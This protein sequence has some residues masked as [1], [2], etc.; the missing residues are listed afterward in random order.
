MTPGKSVEHLVLVV[1]DVHHQLVVA[2]LQAGHARRFVRHRDELDGVEIGVLLAAVADRL[3]AGGLV[4]VEA[5]EAHGRVALP[6]DQPVGAGADVLGGVGHRLVAGGVEDRLGED[7]AGLGV[8]GQ[9]DEDRAVGLGEAELERVVVD[10]GQLGRLLHEALADAAD[11][12]PA[13]DGGDGVG[14]LQLLAVVEHDALAQGHGVGEAVV[15]DGVGGHQLGDRPVLRV[16]GE[17]P[18]VGA[19]AEDGDDLGGRLV[20][21]EVGR[22][23]DGGHAQRA[24]RRAGGGVVLHGAEDGGGRLSRAGAADEHGQG[25]GAEA[26]HGRPAQQRAAVEPPPLPRL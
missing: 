19:V 21:V 24:A 7:R 4:V 8:V 5:L 12:A 11:A 25:G 13:L 22:L 3:V 14:R 9:G 17:E 16:V 6:L 2:G 10:L 26:E 20:L 23:A 15:A 1:A 18:L